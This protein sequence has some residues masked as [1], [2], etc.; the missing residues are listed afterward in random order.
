MKSILISF[1]QTHIIGES[2]KALPEAGYKPSYGTIHTQLFSF[3][4]KSLEHLQELLGL[5]RVHPVPGAL[6]V[7]E[8]RPGERLPDLVVV[9]HRDVVGIAAADEDRLALENG[10]SHVGKVGCGDQRKAIHLYFI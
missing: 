4:E 6:D 2:T 5:L 10:D 9:R 7:L 1:F 3:F 8:R